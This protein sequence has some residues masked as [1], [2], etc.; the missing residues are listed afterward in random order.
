MKHRLWDIRAS[1]IITEFVLYNCG[2]IRGRLLVSV[3]IY[4]EGSLHF[5]RVDK[6]FDPSAIL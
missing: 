1:C 2:P 4:I 3:V 5:E 6:Y